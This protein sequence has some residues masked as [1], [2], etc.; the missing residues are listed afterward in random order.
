MRLL[1]YLIEGLFGLRKADQIYAN[2]LKLPQEISFCERVLQASGVRLGY[3]ESDLAKVPKEGP[4]IVVANLPFGCLE[5]VM[6]LVLLR[7]I[8]PDVKTMANYMLSTIPEMRNDFIFVDPF[9]S[10]NA[11][12]ANLRPLKESLSWLKE[13][14]LLI[15]FPAGE[16]SSFDTKSLRIRDAAW[17]PTVAAFARKSG[18]CVVPMY[19]PGRNSIFFYLMGLI[20]PRLRTILLAYQVANKK[21]RVLK[22][23]IGTPLTQKALEPFST[24]DAQ[25][26]TYMRFRTYLLHE[27]K[28]RRARHFIT[29][30]PPM[31]PAMPI[32]PS[33]PTEELEK[34]IAK[35]PDTS[36]LVAAGDFIVFIATAQQIPFCVHEIGRLREITF[37]AVGEGTGN[38]IDLDKFDPYYMHLVMWNVARKEI[39]GSYRLGLSDKIIEAHGVKGLYT[40]TLFNFDMRLMEKLPP[41]IEM[42]R[43][44]I[45]LEYQKAYT[46]LFLLW[47]GIAMFIAH[48]PKYRAMFGPVSITNEYRE[49]SRCMIL[50]SMRQTCM[51]DDLAVWVKPKFPPHPPQRSEWCLPEY[52]FLLNDFEHVADYVSEIEPDGKD[53]PVLLRQYLKLGGRLLSFNLDPDFSSVVDGLIVVDLA[54]TPLKT[55]RRYMGNEAEAFLKFHGMVEETVTP[56]A[57][58][59]A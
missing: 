44:F 34:E 24:D 36:R 55:L 23:L 19:I 6:L 16:V 17:S 53:I 11:I 52:R 3:K 29:L 32:V 56:A 49:A 45:R 47:R 5:G 9:G 48:N 28:L 7:K 10:K 4:V 21:G 38:E 26:V 39:A 50:A 15:V 58:K 37:R 8:R 30:H 33:V 13:G 54:R 22:T 27:R 20:H 42:G 41:L 35:L 59:E 40:N 43:S 1:G 14:H 46:S 31:M 2:A 18:A 12:K 51:D 57:E 25:L